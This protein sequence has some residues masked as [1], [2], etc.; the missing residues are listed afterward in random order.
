M[1]TPIDVIIRGGLDELSARCEAGNTPVLRDLFAIFASLGPRANAFVVLLVASPFIVPISLGPITTPASLLVLVLGWRMMRHR[2]AAPE[3]IDRADAPSPRFWRSPMAWTRIRLARW[4]Q[5]ILAAAVPRRAFGLMRRYLLMMLWLKNTVLRLHRAVFGAPRPRTA[6]SESH[7][8]WRCG[9]GMV[10]GAILLGVPV[11]LL[12]LTNTFPALGIVLVTLG[13]LE[14]D[15]FLT[16]L[17][18]IAHVISVLIFAALAVAVTWL[19]FEAVT[20][21]LP[22]LM[23]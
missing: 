14:R 23:G 7:A 3:P 2:E 9:L 20:N 11:P 6:A 12:P 1:A 22:R 13:W 10:V 17:G 8:E 16:F 21:W 4:Q 5:W 15:G 19:G 18:W